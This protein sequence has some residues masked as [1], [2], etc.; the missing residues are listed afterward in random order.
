MSVADNRMQRC[1]SGVS[2]EEI[3]KNEYLYTINNQ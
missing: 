1:I 2:R 3:V